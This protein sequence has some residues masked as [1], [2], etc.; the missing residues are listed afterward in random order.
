QDIVVDGGFE[1]PMPKGRL[2]NQFGG[3]ARVEQHVSIANA[4]VLI[5]D[6]INAD[7]LNFTEID[8]TPEKVA[9]FEQRKCSAVATSSKPGANRLMANNVAYSC[10]RPTLGDHA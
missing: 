2:A 5:R 9:H 10:G 6:N 4:A 8:A 1:W 3:V 7:P